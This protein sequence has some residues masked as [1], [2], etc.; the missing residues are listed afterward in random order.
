LRNVSRRRAGTS[1]Y[2]I[3][4]AVTPTT[5]ARLADG[6]ND[7]AARIEDAGREL[8]A[9]LTELERA[10]DNMGEI[11]HVDALRLQMTMNR[12][13]KMVSESSVTTTRITD[14]QGSI[15]KRLR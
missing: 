12:I 7:T 5:I 9:R 8:V 2:R 10:L 4:S 1:C 15:V 14:T 6:I 13:S 11:S 3:D